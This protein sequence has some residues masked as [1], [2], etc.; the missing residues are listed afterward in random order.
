MKKIILGAAL[1]LMSVLS[2]AQTAKTPTVT[3]PAVSTHAVPAKSWSASHPRR[4]QVNKRLDNENR[5]INVER[6]EG[7]ITKSQAHTLRRE[8]K[9][10]RANEKSM[11]AAN[12]GHITKGE[13]KSLNK[14]ENAIS[15]KIGK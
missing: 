13:Q 10:V 8:E 2:F 11:A 1:S 4:T 9:S 14:Q 6:K 12:H 15:K 5:R 3:A 7:E